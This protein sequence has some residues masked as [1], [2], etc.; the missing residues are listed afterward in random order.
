MEESGGYEIR[1][2]AL[3]FLEN[4][5]AKQIT[6]EEIFNRGKTLSEGTRENFSDFVTYIQKILRDIFVMEQAE[7]LNSDLKSRL[8]KIKIPEKV[9]YQLFDEG[10]KIQCKLTSN[11]NL[12]LLAES[13]FLKLKSLTNI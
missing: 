11:A 12:R 10:K 9:L 1:N 2:D 13:Y 3:N 6:V 4:L 7:L 5:L 8:A